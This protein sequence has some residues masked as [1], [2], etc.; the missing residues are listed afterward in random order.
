MIG[1]IRDSLIVQA[2]NGS[3]RMSASIVVR[4]ITPFSS[5]GGARGLVWQFAESPKG[6]LWLA[7]VDEALTHS[8]VRRLDV[9]GHRS[10]GPSS[11]DL[12]AEDTCSDEGVGM[13]AATLA[14]FSKTGHWGLV[15]MK[16]RASRIGAQLR[17]NC[18]PAFGTKLTVLEPA[19]RAS[20]KLFGLRQW[21]PAWCR[22]LN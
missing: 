11:S 7:K 6:D 8:S 5:D 21:L 10:D 4:R 16:E 12:D 15:G 18:A 17:C 9:D 20:K 2:C 19:S 13:D 3:E 1:S 14:A 22:S